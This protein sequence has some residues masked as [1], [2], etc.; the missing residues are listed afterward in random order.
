[1]RD[2]AR[3]AAMLGKV[4]PKPVER[5]Y[6]A[7]ALP[8]QLEMMG[9]KRRKKAAVCG[10]RS[11]KTYG[12]GLGLV[13][14][15]LDAPGLICVYVCLTKTSG[16]YIM[17][18]VLHDIERQHKLGMKFDEQKLLVRLPNGS[19]IML[20]GAD[21]KADMERLRGGKYARVVV[22]EAGSFPR[23]LLGYLLDE[24]LEPATADL[25]GD[26]WLIGSPNPAAAGYFYDATTGG[27]N[28]IA[29][30]PTW[31]WTILENTHVPHGRSEVERIMSEHGWTWDSPIVQREWL[32]KWL[33]DA[34]RLMY[35]YD[36]SRHLCLPPDDIAWNVL[37]VDLGASQTTPSTAFVLMGYR[38]VSSTVWVTEAEKCA[39][40]GPDDIADKIEAYMTRLGG[41]L[42]SIVCDP[43][44]L[45]AGY[46]QHFVER[47]RLPVEFAD[48]KDKQGHIEQLNGDLDGNRL[49]ISPAAKALTSEIEILCWNEKHTDASDATPDHCSDGMLYGWRKCR[50][51]AQ[52]DHAEVR[53]ERHQD[54][55]SW[56]RRVEDRLRAKRPKDERPRAWGKGKI[57]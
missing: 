20:L 47:R 19:E 30:W 17:W 56:M 5:T 25:Q 27:G 35:R 46:V 40:L 23:D 18:P 39:G 53:A 14:R 41:K 33:R 8:L 42:H 2:T 48:K 16:R 4:P 32:G 45:G 28:D 55:A 54:P 12:S 11:G 49:L 10:R 38:A 21:S 1:M 15:A 29:A 24:V 7:P 9:D 57:V 44:G 37:S 13:D 43:G 51:Y 3:V 31:H 50:A 36:P 6:T 26:I 34:T 52:P 22:D